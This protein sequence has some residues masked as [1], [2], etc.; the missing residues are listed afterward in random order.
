MNPNLS[1]SGNVVLEESVNL[2]TCSSVIQGKRV[3]ARTVVGAGAVV[4]RDF[5][6][7]ITAVGIP[8]KPLEG[9]LD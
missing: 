5:P 1:I 2:G 6:S 3:A 7:D 8:A 4:A 9:P